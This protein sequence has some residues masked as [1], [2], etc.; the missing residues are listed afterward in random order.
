MGVVLQVNTGPPQVFLIGGRLTETAIVKTAADGR[1]RIADDHVGD[2][3]Q[4]DPVHHGGRDQ[5]VYAYDRANYD[6]WTADRGHDLPNGFL[7]DNL[8]LSGI[9]VDRARIG[10]RWQVG[11]EV[12]LEV[13]SPRIPCA[14]LDW[15]MQDDF[16]STFLHADR[17]GAYLRIV[18]PGEVAAGDP[19]DVVRAMDH[20]VTVTDVLALWRG[21]DNAEHVLT[22]GDALP[23]ETRARAS[24]RLAR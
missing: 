5:A 10:E 18:T 7:G 21:D 12:V 16:M 1:I 4:A 8:T 6:A 13:T 17:P 2:D 24:A 9:D 23:E 14:K 22:A 19:V 11:D 20:D 15:R 3:V